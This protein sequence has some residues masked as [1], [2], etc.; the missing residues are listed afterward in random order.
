MPASPFCHPTLPIGSTVAQLVQSGNSLLFV[1]LN[2]ILQS[3][4]AFGARD[5]EL[6]Y[7]AYPNAAGAVGNQVGPLASVCYHAAFMAFVDLGSAAKS[8]LCLATQLH[9]HS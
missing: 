7:A 4:A 6:F 8:W 3:A 5:H 1:D 9:Q 2:N